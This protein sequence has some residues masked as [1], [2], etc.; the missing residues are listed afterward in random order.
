MGRTFLE[1]QGLGK[2]TVKLPEYK[3]MEDFWLR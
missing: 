3:E 2:T 1:S